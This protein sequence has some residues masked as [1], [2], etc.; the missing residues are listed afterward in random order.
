MLTCSTCGSRFDRASHLEAHLLKSHPKC[1]T[2][3]VQFK[4]VALFEEHL[5][6]HPKCPV[7]GVLLKNRKELTR[8]YQQTHDA[9][10]PQGV[11]LGKKAR[12][13]AKAREQKLKKRLK[14][15]SELNA[16]A[17]RIDYRNVAKPGVPFHAVV[18]DAVGGKKPGSH[19]SP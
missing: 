1:K 4:T 14:E 8:H 12:A 11:A 7:C 10:R 5:A 17:K 6:G 16:R 2:C 15:R 3:K 19:R 9:R 18:L 13:K